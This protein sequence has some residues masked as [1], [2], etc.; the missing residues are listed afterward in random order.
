M[1][2]I[3]D[4]SVCDRRQEWD[5]SALSYPSIHACLPWLGFELPH[6]PCLPALAG[7]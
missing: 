4:T 3:R 5:F 2:G 1:M 7:V 6:H